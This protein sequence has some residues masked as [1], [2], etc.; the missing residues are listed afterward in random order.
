LTGKYDSSYIYVVS[1]EAIEIVKDVF[2]K[3]PKF[4]EYFVAKE[5]FLQSLCRDPRYK[6]IQSM[7]VRTE[8]NRYVKKEN[9]EQTL[10]RMYAE[11]ED[12]LD[13]EEVLDFLTNRG[14]PKVVEHRVYLENL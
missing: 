13:I 4:A 11:G 3:A 12:Y 1:Q 9:V 10:I 7:W 2:E 6:K 5:K 8:T 14:R